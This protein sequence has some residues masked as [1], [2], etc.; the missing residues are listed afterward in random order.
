VVEV[1]ITLTSRIRIVYKT[2]SNLCVV[3]LVFEY[4]DAD[5]QSC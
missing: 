5:P 4:V 1:V 3:Y 2:C